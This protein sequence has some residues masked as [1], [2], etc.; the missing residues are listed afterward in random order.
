MPVQTVRTM[1][2]GNKVT[3][4]EAL[5]LNVI[6]GVFN[7]TPVAELALFE[8]N[9]ASKAADREVLSKIKTRL[10]S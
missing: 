2:M 7:N 10:H 5:G 8:K 9:F 4:A 1:I 3:S 6:T